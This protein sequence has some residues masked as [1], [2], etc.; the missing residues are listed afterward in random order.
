M[1]TN[2]LDFKIVI[3]ELAAKRGLTAKDVKIA[4]SYRE[5]ICFMKLVMSVWDEEVSEKFCMNDFDFE[6]AVNFILDRFFVVTDEIYEFI[7]EKH[8]AGDT[9]ADWKN[10]IYMNCEDENYMTTLFTEVHTKKDGWKSITNNFDYGKYQDTLE[11]MKEE[12]EM[13]SETRRYT[14]MM[15][16]RS[17]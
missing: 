4:F 13:V 3:D 15:L 12:R 14:E 11:R 10:G 6:D 7:A 9:V 5:G 8:L 17:A 2:L 1:N 16:R